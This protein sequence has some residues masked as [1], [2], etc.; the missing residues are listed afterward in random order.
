MSEHRTPE[1]VSAEQAVEDAVTAMLTA[2]GFPGV[3]ADWVV[4]TAS[5]GSK[6]GDVP[7]MGF[8]PREGQPSYRSLGLLDYAQARLRAHAADCGPP[9]EEP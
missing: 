1:Q 3:L 7:A 4:L 2:E 8:F 6:D 5:Y 9:E